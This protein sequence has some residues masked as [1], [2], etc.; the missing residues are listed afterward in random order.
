MGVGDI[1]KE[2]KPP[3]QEA[4]ISKAGLPQYLLAHDN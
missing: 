2:K 1:I 4:D 3:W